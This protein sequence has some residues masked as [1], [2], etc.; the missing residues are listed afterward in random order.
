MAFFCFQSYPLTPEHIITTYSSKLSRTPHQPTAVAS[1]LALPSCTPC[2]K[3]TRRLA[4]SPMLHEPPHFHVTPQ[5]VSSI[6]NAFNKSVCTIT[7]IT[8]VSY[9][10]TPRLHM[11]LAF[12]PSS[13]LWLS[14]V[15]VSQFSPLSYFSSQLLSLV[16]K[17]PSSSH[18]HQDVSG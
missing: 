14:S 4:I 18:L 9:T 5:A 12:L 11:R 6:W 10:P 8:Q 15:R 17:V 3:M 16:Y 2:L 1:Y 7:T 13:G